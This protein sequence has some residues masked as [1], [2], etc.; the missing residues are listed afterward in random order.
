MP[1]F[2]PLI[3]SIQTVSS[4]SDPRRS[5]IFRGDVR[6]ATWDGGGDLS[7]GAD[8]TATSGYLIDYSSGSAQF[9]NL[10]AESFAASS[11]D[12]T[13]DTG[14]ITVTAGDITVTAGDIE[15][16]A[17]EITGLPWST[18]SPSYTNITIGNGSVTARKI[19]IGKIVFARF[20]LTFG[21]TTAFSGQP[22]VSLPVTASSTAAASTD[23]PIGDAQFYDDTGNRYQ[24]R[25]FLNT[26]TTAVATVLSASAT[27]AYT[28]ALSSTIPFTW[29]TNDKYSWAIRYEAA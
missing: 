20:V 11:G 12:I 10:Y 18:W 13:L 29:T 8:S 22:I 24:G 7:G 2:P 5:N 19:Q 9:K 21:T 17:G 15:V 4:A 27:Y 3:D 6:S 26:T 14:S 16:T 28:T 23:Q 1:E 25:A